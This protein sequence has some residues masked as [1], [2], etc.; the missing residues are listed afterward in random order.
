MHFFDFYI[1]PNNPPAES[2]MAQR[3]STT[4][5]KLFAHTPKD[6]WPVLGALAQGALVIIWF[7]T[8]PFAPWWVVISLGFIFACCISWNV[9]SI[10]HNFVH[11]PYFS[12]DVLNRAFGWW[13]SV[14]MGF[15]QQF[16]DRVH[17]H[18]HMGNSDRPDESGE[19]A[20]WVSIY[21]HGHEGKPE[22][23]WTYTFLSIFRDDPV[24]IFRELYKRRPFDAYWGVFELLSWMALCADGF[25]LNWRFMLCYLPFFYLGHSLSYLNGYY[26]HY[27]ANP[28]L[29]IA[30]GVSSSSKLYNFLW[31]NNGYHAEHHF[32]PKV[33]WTKMAALH[34]EIK[35]EQLR[36][37]VMV[38]WPPHALAF[39]DSKIS[40]KGEHAKD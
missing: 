21:R 5:M 36:A 1:S 22:S 19:T 17:Q 18:H 7:L 32:R 8:F 12:S 28:D 2:N 39:L 24:R 11:N 6:A 9:N 38:I 3:R 40:G 34:E 16:Y 31:F 10:A 26:M 33:H 37:G 13:Q 29:P 35:D 4:I 30:W 27:K 15:S 14:I 20:D 23:V 25:Y